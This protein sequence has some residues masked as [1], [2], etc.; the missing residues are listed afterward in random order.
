MSYKR[1]LELS[2]ILLLA[3]KIGVGGSLAYFIANTMN[4]QFAASAGTIT[5]LTLQTTKWE[6]MKLSLRRVVS[7]YFTYGACM[8]LACFVRIPWLDYGIFLFI[9]VALCEYLGWRSAI[10]VNAV[11]ASHFLS[12]KDFSTEFMMNEL[13]LVMIGITIAIIL[14]LFYITNQH[15]KGITNSM[16]RV[17]RDMKKIFVELAG[18]LKHQKIGEHVWDD[19]RKLEAELDE[20]ED[21][22]HEYQN[23]TFE[24][25][26]E[27]YANY[28]R[29]RKQQCVLLHN[30]H[31]ELRRMSNIPE[32]ADIVSEFMLELSDHVIEL[33]YPTEQ[34]ENLNK[35]FEK[36]KSYPFPTT[37]E[38]FEDRVLL[39]HVFM[40]FE[41]F[42]LIKQ[43]F[44][45]SINEEQFRIY[46][47]KEIQNK[48][49]IG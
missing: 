24:E 46:W 39:Y 37:A 34:F 44:V 33:N 43:R 19:I 21:L 26:T 13:M 2:K 29:M 38:E 22:A 7:F 35:A 3:L 14:N 5:L 16:R 27:F 25:H 11:T 42:L 41:D 23:N 10:S 28:F 15:E 49:D 32:E 45:S 12:T 36:I 30:L 20:F 6:T 1:K 8:T 17:E 47:K 9:L 18:Y 4:L 31:S 40:Y 48:A